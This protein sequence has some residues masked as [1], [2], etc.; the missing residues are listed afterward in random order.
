MSRA[1]N[2]A[3]AIPISAA[4][5]SPAFLRSIETRRENL[6]HTLKEIEREYAIGPAG[7][8]ERL[9]GP[10]GAGSGH[11]AAAKRLAE[12][13]ARRAQARMDEM[14]IVRHLRKHT[15]RSAHKLELDQDRRGMRA[16]PARR[17]QQ[18]RRISVLQGVSGSTRPSHSIPAQRLRLLALEEQMLMPDYRHRRKS[19]NSFPPGGAYQSQTFFETLKGNRSLRGHVTRRPYCPFPD[20]A[21]VSATDVAKK[22]Q[23]RHFAPVLPSS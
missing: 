16:A 12:M 2:S 9:P 6:R 21:A 13:Q 10:Q 1:K 7:P 17:R 20:R 11:R 23:N 8:A 4:W 15:L 18:P 22:P 19:Q 14:A 3:P 5:P